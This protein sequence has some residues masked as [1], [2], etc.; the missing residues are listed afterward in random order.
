MRGRQI[1][2]LMTA[3]NADR[4]LSASL[5]SV[6][7]Q[8]CH[9]FRAIIINDGS[10]DGTAA[11]LDE[12]A[13]QDSRIQVVHQ[14]RAGIVTTANRGLA[15]CEAEFVARM[16]ADDISFPD[17]LQQQLDYLRA[18]PDCV[19]VSGACYHID[20]SGRR[21]GYIV[22]LDPPDRADP[23]ATPSREPYI[24]HTFLM[25]RRE[26]MQQIGGY[27]YADFAEDTDLYW[28]LQ[29]VGRLGLMPEI[30]GEYRVHPQSVSSHAVMHGRISAINSQLSG[31]SAIRRRA[32]SADLDFKPEDF[33]NLT[34][35][36]S[37]A[38]MHDY[39]SAKLKPAEAEYFRL[40][41]A[42]KLLE[43]SAFRPYELETA[44]CRFIR[45]A[46]QAGLPTLR[47][48][49]RRRVRGEWLHGAARL[50]NKGMF[51]EFQAL[52][53]KEMTAEALLRACRLAVEALFPSHLIIRLK[54]WRRRR[55]VAAEP[56]LESRPSEAA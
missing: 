5:S 27:R 1:D 33:S 41:L 15:M 16:D 2:V 31:L 48:A 51:R 22:T 29:E 11:I 17:R 6:L 36:A 13:R 7:A 56:V 23:F 21:T 52:A 43:L 46:V 34:A 19:A 10:T 39:A 30:L 50:L 35:R 38:A 28:R 55:R 42:A 37:L 44:D 20:E 49:D 25:A 26:A 4:T 40:A 3:Y 24:M 32:G 8:T 9:S 14:Q 47:P 54:M 53:A 12:F 45:S 18:H